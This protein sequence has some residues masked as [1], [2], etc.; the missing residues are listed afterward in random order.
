MKIRK[1]RKYYNDRE[2][3]DELKFEVMK[4]ISETSGFANRPF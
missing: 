1:R 4:S 2:Y 3:L